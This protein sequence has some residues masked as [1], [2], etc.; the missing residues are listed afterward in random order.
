MKNYL[1]NFLVLRKTSINRLNINLA[2]PVYLRE[3][4]TN[5]RTT[6][7]INLFWSNQPLKIGVCDCLIG[8]DKV[9]GTFWSPH[10][11][12]AHH[13]SHIIAYD[14][15]DFFLSYFVFDVLQS[16]LANTLENCMLPHCSHTDLFYFVSFS[17]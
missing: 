10:T 16:A 15:K 3:I 12:I 17:L 13:C 14:W 8:N 9:T 5:F 11:I 2:A 7:P 6:S 4:F 1:W